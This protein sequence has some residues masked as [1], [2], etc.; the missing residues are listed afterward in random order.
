MQCFTNI[1][2]ISHVGHVCFVCIVWPLR[3][4]HLIG[5][6]FHFAMVVH[7]ICSCACVAMVVHVICLCVCMTC[8]HRPLNR[9]ETSHLYTRQCAVWSSRLDK[10]KKIYTNIP[11]KAHILATAR[12]RALPM[13]SAS[14]FFEVIA[15][16]FRCYLPTVCHENVTWYA[17]VR[18]LSGSAFTNVLCGNFREGFQAR[19]TLA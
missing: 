4:W 16:R 14:S 6:K 19:W 7:V 13:S 18:L 1:S 12:G 5:A 3:F 15:I 11:S 2:W 8:A 17:S 10:I 9:Q